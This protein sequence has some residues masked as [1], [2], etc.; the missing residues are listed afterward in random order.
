MDLNGV[1]KQI[2]L[3]DCEVIA[4]IKKRMELALRL[5][6]IKTNV[7][8]PEREKEVIENVRRCSRGVIRPGFSETLYRD[9]MEE[10]KRLQQM[11]VSLIGFQGEHGAYSE[12]ASLAY[13]PS[14]APIPCNGFREVF[15]E[16]SA[17]RLDYGIVPVENSLEGAVT[18]VNDLLNETDLTIVGEIIT[19]I[20]H[21]LLALPETDYRDLRIVW[22]HPQAL[23]QCRGFIERL[24]LET[25]PFYDTAG[26]AKILSETRPDAT[27]VIAHRL[28]A[29]IYHIDV[30]KENIED[31]ESNATRFIV[32][33]R[34]ESSEGGDKCSIIFTIAHRA[35]ALFTILTI[36]SD[37]QINLTRIESRPGKTGLGNYTFFLD[38]EGSDKDEKVA[39]SLKK[40]EEEAVKYKF[41]GCYSSSKNGKAN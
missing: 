11:P 38:F 39:E 30:I 37:R 36:F 17:G 9:I 15:D 2:D 18:E 26:A 33:S 32:L 14:M 6:N 8:E 1:R 4:R 20:H 19:P 21:C 12:A 31:H 7:F 3:I 13:D 23:G 27:G 10:S 40:V 5:K 22:S 34:E 41:L 29:D 35:S 25:R 28:C 16:V 24:K